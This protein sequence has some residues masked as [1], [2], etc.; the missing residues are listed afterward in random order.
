MT[1]QV[2]SRFGIGGSQAAAI[3]GQNPYASPIDVFCEIKGIGE[4]FE[5]NEAT[6]WG[7]AKE[8]VVR[9]RYFSD[10]R[11]DIRIPD[12]S[13]FH[14]DHP[15]MRATPDGIVFDPDLL[16]PSNTYGLEVKTANSRVA[17]RW[18]PSGSDTYPAEYRVQCLW[19]MHVTGLDRWDIA[20]LIDSA[21]YREYRIDRTPE[22][23]AEI[24]SIV[25]DVTRFWHD[26]IIADVAPDPDA[27]EGYA[28]YLATMHP[29]ATLGEMVEV[30]KDDASLLIIEISALKRA[31]E[32]IKSDKAK[33]ARCENIIKA[34]IGDAPGITSDL[35]TIKWTEQ[36]GRVNW[37]ALAEHLHKY[38]M[39]AGD[40]ET[41][42]DFQ[43]KFRGD[44]T[45]VMRTP[46]SWGKK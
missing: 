39:E 29:R 31:K 6:Y 8:G 46:R 15:W 42:E 9:Q 26:H 20:V 44:R 12:G 11:V 1:G 41:L 19:Y 28:R 4:P 14:P 22:V 21:D 27:S 33:V 35:G 2:L 17:H 30:T 45:R 25:E 16:D 23:Q 7:T 37:K 5:G 10:H 13:I 43:N 24:D 38:F 18:G 3:I 36:Q 32:R 34:A 40:V